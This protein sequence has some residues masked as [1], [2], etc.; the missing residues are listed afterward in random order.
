MVIEKFKDDKTRE[1]YYRY[2]QRGRM[3]PDGLKYIDSQVE[4]NFN[5]CFQLMECDDL[6][7]FQKWTLQ[8]QDLVDFE[9]IPVVLS[10]DAA[11]VNA[12]IN[13]VEDLDDENPF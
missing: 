8:W 4:V 2:Q 9:V 11:N 13:A 1:V 5:R 10:K 12:E 7:L 6:T 3:L